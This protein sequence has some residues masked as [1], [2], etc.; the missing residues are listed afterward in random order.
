MPGLP[1]VERPGGLLGVRVE[2]NKEAAVLRRLP[3]DEEEMKGDGMKRILKWSALAALCF[4]LGA[5]GYFA[6]RLWAWANV[7]LRNALLDPRVERVVQELANEDTRQR[8][9]IN[10]IGR[11]LSPSGWIDCEGTSM[12]LVMP[13]PAVDAKGMVTGGGFTFEEM[14]RP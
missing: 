1:E 12:T 4:G 9:A 8:M 10:A 3:G 6:P 5:A 2:E 13:R 7:R 14:K 11:K